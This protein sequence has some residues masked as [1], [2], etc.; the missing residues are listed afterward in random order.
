MN[1]MDTKWE[2]S[3]CP[4][5]TDRE[6]IYVG[7]QGQSWA[8]RPG[9]P[10]AKGTEKKNMFFFLFC[11]IRSNKRLQCSREA[12]MKC[13]M[14]CQLSAP[15][16]GGKYHGSKWC[17]LCLGL[18]VGRAF[19]VAL[20]QTVLCQAG[21]TLLR[22]IFAATGVLNFHFLTSGAMIW[23]YTVP[24]NKPTPCKNVVV[25]FWIIYWSILTY[26]GSM[27]KK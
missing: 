17:Q 16:M 11:Y 24:S 9:C 19:W 2:V 26:Y 21:L 1:S 18:P 12:N 6:V 15:K 14:N 3:A 5:T 22:W 7:S 13:S 27:T 8:P 10:K 25:F 4:V 23:W 20:A